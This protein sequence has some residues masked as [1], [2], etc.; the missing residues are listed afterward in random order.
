MNGSGNRDGAGES[1]G[2]RARARGG[3]NKWG[4]DLVMVHVLV[5]RVG[6]ALRRGPLRRGPDLRAARKG[7]EMRRRGECVVRIPR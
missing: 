3:G 6:H 1:K 5:V 7:A 4:L 2:E